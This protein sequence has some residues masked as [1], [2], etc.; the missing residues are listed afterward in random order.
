M[1]CERRGSNVRTPAAQKQPGSFPLKLTERR[2]ERQ[3]DRLFDRW[4][5]AGREAAV[6]FNFYQ[7]RPAEELYNWEADPYE[8]HTHSGSPRRAAI[9]QKLVQVLDRWMKQQGDEGM[10][11][12]Q[13]VDERTNKRR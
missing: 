6:R 1:R 5:T 13:R 4:P 2:G 12:E 11:A 8:L 10:G 7:H 3:E 9:Q